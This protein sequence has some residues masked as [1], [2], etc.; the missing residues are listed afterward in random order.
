MSR[1]FIREDDLSEPQDESKSDVGGKVNESAF[2]VKF[3]RD[4]KSRSG[5]VFHVSDANGKNVKLTQERYINVQ[6]NSKFSHPCAIFI[7]D[8]DVE[9]PFPFEFSTFA[10]F[11]WATGTQNGLHSIPVRYKPHECKEADSNE[12]IAAVNPWI[13]A[14][15]DNPTSATDTT[16]KAKQLK[17]KAWYSCDVTLNPYQ[18]SSARLVIENSPYISGAE[19]LSNE[20]IMCSSCGGFCKFEGGNIK[21]PY[22]APQLA[23]GSLTNAVFL[24][25]AIQNYYETK[26]TAAKTVTSRWPTKFVKSTNPM[27]PKQLATLLETAWASENPFFWFNF[28]GHALGEISENKRFES[29]LYFKFDRKMPT[30]LCLATLDERVKAYEK[31]GK[32]TG[33]LLWTDENVGPVLTL[34]RKF[35]SQNSEQREQTVNELVGYHGNENFPT[36]NR[37]GIV[38]V[39]P[40]TFYL[41]HKLNVFKA[42]KPTERLTYGTEVTL[43][44][45][46]CIDLA[47]YIA[48]QSADLTPGEKE[49]IVEFVKKVQPLVAPALAKCPG[50]CALLSVIHTIYEE[51]LERPDTFWNVFNIAKSK[52]WAI[53]TWKTVKFT[54]DAISKT[55]LAC[56]MISPA[57]TITKIKGF[58]PL[59]QVTPKP[60]DV[61]K[62]K[63]G[64]KEPSSFLA[65]VMFSLF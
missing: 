8:D 20:R 15:N 39:S 25:D 22:V 19:R 35:C 26:E 33:S 4:I 7:P 56:Y 30:S 18:P 50:H 12:T 40:V 45:L 63:K 24:I 1:L 46:S 6:S 27:T 13:R 37:S 54:P 55:D 65:T 23:P 17:L 47:H 57:Q 10:L 9:N 36:R 38:D 31:V 16:G 41:G 11:A 43:T 49:L 2:F 61:K 64:N 5:G 52:P 51:L 62:R 59:P 58:D 34:L 44:M 60:N 42:D 53:Q 32:E 3:V 48:C 14:L 21:Y 28:V 29:S